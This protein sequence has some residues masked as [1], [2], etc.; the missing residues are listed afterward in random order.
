MPPMKP[1]PD[2]RH[3]SFSFTEPDFMY[4]SHCNDT[5]TPAWDAGDYLP[6]GELAISPAAAFMSYGLGIFEG[7]K[8]QRCADGRV[9]L[10]RVDR[11][12]ERFRRSAERMMLAPFPAQQFV[13]ACVETV[14]RNLR[15]VPP[16]DKGSFYLR[17]LEVANGQRLGLG[18]AH[19]FLVIVYGCAVGA[20]FGGV[21]GGVRL[22]V[23]EQGRVPAGGTG[24]AK[25]MGNYSGG[26]K[27]AYDAKAKGFDDVLYLD[28]HELK[29]VSETSGSNVFVKLRNGT[30]VTPPLSDQILDGNTRASTVQLAR[31]VLG[32]KVEER[33]ISIDETLADGEEVFAS[34]TAWTLLSVRE[35]VHREKAYKFPATATRETLLK[36]LRGIQCG[37]AEDR[38]RWTREVP[39]G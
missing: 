32:M 5:K 24:A 27:I 31:D 15:H 28:A 3:L 2:W 11:N 23:L 38:F 26:I 9:L 29:W 21:E 36:L 35:L 17:P 30:L 14:R 12:A 16:H 4:V 20:Y 34:G 18:P 10:F 6:F 25:C 19:E 37:T 1:L 33:P 8:A 39:Q 13:D 7:L 22:L